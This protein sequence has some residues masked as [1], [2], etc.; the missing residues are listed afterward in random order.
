MGS[1]IWIIFLK[2]SWQYKNFFLY[3]SIYRK[4]KQP[5]KNHL[6]SDPQAYELC[7]ELASVCPQAGDALKSRGT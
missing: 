3:F 6:R 1:F 4:K 5:D 2:I 7:A